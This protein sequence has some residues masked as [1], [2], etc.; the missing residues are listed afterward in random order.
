MTDCIAVLGMDNRT[1]NNKINLEVGSYLDLS[2]QLYQ[3]FLK[4]NSYFITFSLGEKRTECQGEV[5]NG[6]CLSLV[7]IESPDKA[8]L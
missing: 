3:Q 8:V 7:H 6:F 1:T 4:Q 2:N 5:V